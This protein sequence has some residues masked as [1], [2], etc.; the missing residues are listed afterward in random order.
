MSSPEK[1]RRESVPNC[2]QLTEMVVISSWR[3]SEEGRASV[4]G[5]QVPCIDIVSNARVGARFPLRRCEHI[6]GEI[7]SVAQCA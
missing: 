7:P 1:R 3:L 4:R 2:R 5:R 6:N